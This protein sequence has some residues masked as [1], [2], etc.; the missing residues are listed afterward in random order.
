VDE[1]AYQPALTL[2]LFIFA[3]VIRYR[4]QI[5]GSPFSFTLLCPVGGITATDALSEAMTYATCRSRHQ[6]YRPDAMMMQMPSHFQASG[7]S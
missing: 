1:S 2:L 7:T 6:T 4:L 5:A 3:A